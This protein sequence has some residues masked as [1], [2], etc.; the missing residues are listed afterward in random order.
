MFVSNITGRGAAPALLA[1]MTFNEARLRTIAENV[2]NASTPGYR[3]KQLDTKGFQSALRKAFDNRGKNASK[4]FSID[5]GD[6]VRTDAMGAL[7]VTPSLAP[8][9]NVLFHD[10]TNMSIEKQM[11]DL[12]ETAMSN[13]LT[14]TILS[15]YFSGLRKAI[16]G[17]V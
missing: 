14:S 3:A 13:E 6:E 4:P 1:T 5:G 10:G 2:A 15:G 16:R 17:S 7:R 8:V 12:A 9:E 11:S